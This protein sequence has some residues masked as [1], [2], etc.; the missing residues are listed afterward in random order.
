M[1]YLTVDPNPVGRPVAL[2]AGDGPAGDGTLGDG[3][4]EIGVEPWALAN[5]TCCCRII[6]VLL[7]EVLGRLYG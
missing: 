6:D 5:L 7:V 4:A 1:A 3:I 2:V